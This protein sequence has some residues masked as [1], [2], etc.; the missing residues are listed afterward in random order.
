[1]KAYL[2][3]TL[4]VI[5]QTILMPCLIVL[6][7]LIIV[8]LWQVGDILVETFK[9]RKKMKEDV[10]KLLRKIHHGGKEHI[11]ETIEGSMLLNRQKQ[12]LFELID[13]KDMARPSLEALAER[14]L[15]TEQEKY[16]KTIS[17]TDLVAKLGPMFGL[18][19]TLIPLGPGIVALG[20]GDTATLASSIGIAFDTT[21]AGMLGASIALVISSIR[22]R[23]YNGYMFSLESIMECILEEVAPDVRK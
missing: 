15:A 4:H 2:S 9:E 18:L 17:I 12:A 5:G 23:W 13:S 10:P 11:R 20:K 7:A 16:E 6:I 3:S 21:I 1:M 19:G 22:K 8:A 14:L